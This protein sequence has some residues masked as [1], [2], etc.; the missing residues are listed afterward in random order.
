MKYCLILLLS[1]YSLTVSAQACYFAG[2]VEVPGEFLIQYRGDIKGFCARHN[3]RF[4]RTVASGWQMYLLGFDTRRM[5]ETEAMALA[6]R[7]EG[8][9]AVQLNHRI[10]DRTVEPNDPSWSQQGDMELIKAPEAWEA[11]TG[12]LTPNGDTIV[13]AVL[14]KGILFTHP[15]LAPNRWYNRGEIAGNGIDDDQNGYIDD[16]GGWN[17]RFLNDN[18]GTNGTHGTGVAGIVGAKGNN[19]LGVTGVNWNVKIMGLFN[20]EFE[21]EILE[22]YH[23]VD[24]MRQIYNAT[25]GQRGAFVVSTNA[26][27]GL[28]NAFAADHPLW[29]AAYDSLGQRGI[30]SVGATS[31][32]DT[33][34]D[35]M[36]DMPTTCTS[37]FL[38]TVNNINQQGVKMPATG[39]GAVSI[40]LGA[41]GHDTYTTS[42]NGTNNPGYNKL[43][44]TSAA[45]PHVTGAVGLLY[46]FDCATFT[47]DALTAPATC[48]R[49]V[50]DA[51]LLNTEP[52]S[53]LQGITVT[54]GHLSLS[55][56]LDAV[57]DLCDGVV[58]TLD[59]LEVRTRMD[60][61]QWEIFYQ[62]PDFGTYQFRVF[63]MLG[64]IIYEEELQP[65][66]FS[67]NRVEFD[68]KN[69]P[70]GVYVA[71]I[72]RGKKVVSRKFPKI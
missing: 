11:S 15:D 14:E 54:G 65:D 26:S 48:A 56:A 52:N 12:G 24:T 1:I 66:Q 70:S 47:S 44:G 10:P 36:G 41:P 46:S 53:T 58:G 45:T 60:G 37:E 33:N 8:T 57:R 38:I 2:P 31:N 72:G 7:E 32:Q 62:T 5:T 64:Q 43:G 59:V 16:F 21:D 42:N 49:R 18:T 30:V 9:I 3:F 39:Y 23:Y 68:A 20:V 34:V 28:N 35:Q 25:N 61:T 22:A 55:K 27:F 29:C 4:I 13:V 67:A 17:P 6:R 19:N 71:T 63:N 40:D 50:R 69:L 51:I